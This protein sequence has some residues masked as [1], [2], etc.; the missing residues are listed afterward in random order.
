MLISAAATTLH[1]TCGNA[2]AG[3][4]WEGSAFFNGLISGGAFALMSE[5]ILPEPEHKGSVSCGYACGG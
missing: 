3:R 2:P 5:P 4:G 1:L